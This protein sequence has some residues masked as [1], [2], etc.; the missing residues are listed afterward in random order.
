MNKQLFERLRFIAESERGQEF[1][2]TVP[3]DSDAAQQLHVRVDDP[4]KYPVGT[5]LYFMGEDYDED[6]FWW[7][8]FTTDKAL[9]TAT[10]YGS[11]D[12][13]VIRFT[14]LRYRDILRVV[15]PIK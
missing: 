1:K 5:T 15:E 2:L 11:R 8:D 3:L 7:I 10:S 12:P 4:K 9:L 13:G 14:P 6:G